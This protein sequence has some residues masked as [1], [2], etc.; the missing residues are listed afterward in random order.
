ML[1][2]LDTLV[3]SPRGR[4]VNATLPISLLKLGV[5]D[6]VMGVL[7]KEGELGSLCKTLE[8]RRFTGD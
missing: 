8:F 2:A 6:G 1:T 7:E 3:G 5:F 4:G